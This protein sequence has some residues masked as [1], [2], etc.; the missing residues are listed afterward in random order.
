MQ[1]ALK[2]RWKHLTFLFLWHTASCFQSISY[3]P[4]S[5]VFFRFVFR[6]Y[7]VRNWA[8]SPLYAPQ[9]LALSWKEWFYSNVR[10]GAACSIT[11]WPFSAS[12]LPSRSSYMYTMDY[13]HILP[14]TT[15][16][17]S[18]NIF[19]PKLHVLSLSLFKQLIRPFNAA[20][21]CIGMGPFI[22]TW[23]QR[24]LPWGRMILPSPVVVI[25]FN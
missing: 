21:M 10:I 23:Y 7:S 1:D 16:E 22:R 6:F 24:L 25:A 4:S 15:S 9:T 3:F 14:C 8:Q 11:D 17:P 2:F 5:Y 18:S 20:H 12:S 19:P 13:D